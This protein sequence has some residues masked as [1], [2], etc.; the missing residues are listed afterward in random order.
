MRSV[1]A[2]TYVR[3]YFEIY[4][5]LL[6]YESPMHYLK[7]A[8]IFP[9]SG[10]IMPS[11][12][13]NRESQSEHP[14]YASSLV[15]SAIVKME[16]WTSRKF[17]AETYSFRFGRPNNWASF[18]TPPNI[19][20]AWNWSVQPCSTTSTLINPHQPHDR[21]GH[22]RPSASEAILVSIFRFKSETP[23]RISII[24]VAL[25]RSTT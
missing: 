16:T 10:K 3:F 14:F 1:R 19:F 5:G 17:G 11:V 13:A 23:L 12:N 24:C 6:L 2:Y 15:L 25:L 21:K 9:C 20:G 7:Q 18:Q 4:L 22:T 8:P